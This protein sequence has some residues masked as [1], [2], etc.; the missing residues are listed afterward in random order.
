[1]DDLTSD[2]QVEL[3]ADL[4]ALKAV[5]ED[6]LRLS[7]TG[8]KPV[9]LDTAFGRVSRID[10]IQQQQMAKAARR[11][12]DIRLRQTEAALSALARDEYGEC[13]ACEEPIGYRRLKAQP[14]T[15]LCVACRSATER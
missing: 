15:P 12:Q 7:K 5:L 3:A 1:M 14:E 13:R 4:L 11:S 8:S 10:A 2:Q 6:Q 9:E